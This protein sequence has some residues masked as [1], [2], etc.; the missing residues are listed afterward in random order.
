M[1]VSK[2]VA[3]K[4]SIS[5]ADDDSAYLKA[6]LRL[7]DETYTADLSDPLSERFKSLAG[8]LEDQLMLIYK[9]VPDVRDVNV[10]AFRCVCSR[11]LMITPK[12]SLP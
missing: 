5:L 1:S 4:A 8:F 7:H 2:S 11:H 3:K 12:F 6:V 10:V 9:N